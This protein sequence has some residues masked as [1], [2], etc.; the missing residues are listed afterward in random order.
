MVQAYSR[1]VPST[2]VSLTSPPSRIRRFSC[3]NS[4][5]CTKIR[6]GERKQRENEILATWSILFKSKSEKKSH[7]KY[8][9][10]KSPKWMNL[11][12]HSKLGTWDSQA[13]YP[14]ELECEPELSSFFEKSTPSQFCLEI[15]EHLA[16]R[17]PN[18]GEIRHD[19][20]FYSHFPIYGDRL[21][22]LRGYMDSQ[23]PQGLRA[24]WRD[25]RNSNTYYTFWFVAIFGSLSVLLATCALA[26]S[27][28]QTWAAFHPQS[29]PSPP[30]S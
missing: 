5:L 3:L 20:V 8:G 17:W 14:D 19:R 27:I 9:R 7:R 21:R 30:T 16:R 4:R 15:D 12:A 11:L 13:Q 29:Q 2:K 1:T 25:R 23:D 18:L 22:E 28:A 6:F 26:V 24:L 10:L